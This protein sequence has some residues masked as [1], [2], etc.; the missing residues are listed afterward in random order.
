LKSEHVVMKNLP[1]FP[2]NARGALGGGGEGG[3]VPGNSFDHMGLKRSEL[4]KLR[5]SS[6]SQS[7]YM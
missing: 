1:P 2:S 3:E 5:A 4:A 7:H 6:L